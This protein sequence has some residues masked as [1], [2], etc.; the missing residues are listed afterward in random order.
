MR[1]VIQGR[2]QIGDFRTL[3]REQDHVAVVKFR[4]GDLAETASV[5][6]LLARSIVPDRG[7]DDA[8]APRVGCEQGWDELT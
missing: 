7:G 6:D 5:Q 3:G 8:A 1:H 4:L 2:G